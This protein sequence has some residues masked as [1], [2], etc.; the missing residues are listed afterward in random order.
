MEFFYA[1]GIISKQF[2]LPEQESFHCVKV[3]RHIE[4]DVIHIVD[5]I[6]GLYEVEI[7]R[8]HKEHCAFEIIKKINDYGRKNYFLHIAIA[9]PKSIERLEWFIEKATEIGIDTI[10][11]LICEHSER[12]KI[13]TDRLGNILV[14]AMKQSL[15]AYL[16]ELNEPSDFFQFVN[17]QKSIPDQKFICHIDHNNKTYLSSVC[18]RGAD[19]L[20]LIGP[21]GG[22]SPKEVDI[23]VQNNFQQV[24]L[25]ESRLRTETAGLMACCAVNLLNEI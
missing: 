12:R 10:T 7:T 4:G 9:P 5:G 6:G 25:G 13:K 8:A 19:V 18:S 2:T 17:K 11:P 14:S 15:K 3:L 22:F 23:A 24:T 21:E 20:V 1:H 16:P